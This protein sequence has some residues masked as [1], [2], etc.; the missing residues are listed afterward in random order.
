MYFLGYYDH[1][2]NNNN[3]NNS[4]CSSSNNDNV[5]LSVNVDINPSHYIIVSHVKVHV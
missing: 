1:M 5:Y 3:S 4:S 2:I